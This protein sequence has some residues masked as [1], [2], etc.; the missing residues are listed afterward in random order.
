MSSARYAADFTDSS[1]L[2][3][4]RPELWDLPTTNGDH[5]T[6]DGI[7]I[8]S[9]IG[10]NLVDMEKVQVHPTGLVDPKEA[11]AKVKF[12]A[13]EALRG[14]GGILLDGNGNR[15]CDE[16]VKDLKIVP[17]SRLILCSGSS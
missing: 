6:G 4:Y 10:G 13:A 15:F 1:L 5:S 12:L 17:F 14:V 7:K 9:Q 11:D 3:K 2:K 8:A 16:L